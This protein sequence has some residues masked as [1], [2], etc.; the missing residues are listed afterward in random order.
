MAGTTRCD[1][2]VRSL[3]GR[4]SSSGG[5]VCLCLVGGW[6]W[7]I[8]LHCI[9]VDGF[10]RKVGKLRLYDLEFRRNKSRSAGSL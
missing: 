5:R 8:R 7:A 9:L 2:V 3:R 10:K 4:I 1:G 6:W